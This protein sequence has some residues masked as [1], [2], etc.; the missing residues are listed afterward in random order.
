MNQKKVHNLISDLK[1][2]SGRGEILTINFSKN[3][4]TFIIDDSYNANPASM[5]AALHNFNKLKLKLHKFETVIIIGDML[6][7]GKHSTKKHL[8]LIP[9]LLKIN[10]DLLL[11]LGNDTK[12]INDNLKLT[13]NCYSYYQI[14]ELIIDI[15][16]FIKPNQII[17]LKGSNG[18]GLWRLVSIFKDIIQ[19]NANAA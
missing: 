19:E 6:E 14:D 9:I 16:Q 11:T 12:K 2:L 7:L 4:K 18:T 13:L 3:E 17:L 8:E 5:K 15:K 10:P 1:P